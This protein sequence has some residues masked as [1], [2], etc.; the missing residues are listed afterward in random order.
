MLFFLKQLEQLPTSYSYEKLKDKI[1][2]GLVL[3]CL[4][5]PT[6][7]I[8]YK[9]SRLGNSGF[10]NFIKKS[11]NINIREFTPINGSNERHFCFPTVDFPIGQFARTIYQKYPEYQ[12]H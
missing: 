4:G 3:T 6:Q 8:S 9:E 1:N 10:D 7:N 11:G 12:L 2:Y 5:G